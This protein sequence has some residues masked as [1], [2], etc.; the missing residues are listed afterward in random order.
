MFEQASIGRGGWRKGGK[1]WERE[2]ERRGGGE[3]VGD[4]WMEDGTGI[5]QGPGSGSQNKTEMME[6]LRSGQDG[7]VNRSRSSWP[8]SLAQGDT[9]RTKRT[10]RLRDQISTREPIAENDVIASWASMGLLQPV[11]TAE[12]G[13]W[14]LQFRLRQALHAMA[15]LAQ[16]STSLT[17]LER[18]PRP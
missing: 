10:S 3:R 18:T 12:N 5:S 16:A 11:R 13:C 15:P 6:S 1:R 4:G 14:R 8:R 17:R 7:R 2:K 9:S